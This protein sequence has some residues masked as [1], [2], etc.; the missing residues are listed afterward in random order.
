MDTFE[1]RDR[2]SVKQQRKRAQDE[3]N[4]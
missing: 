4:S 1:I 2:K 3:S